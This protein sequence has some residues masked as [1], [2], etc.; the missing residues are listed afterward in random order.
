[1]RSHRLNRVRGFGP[2]PTVRAAGLMVIAV[3]LAGCASTGADRDRPTGSDV[4]QDSAG[5]DDEE[6]SATAELFAACD[7]EHG[8]RPTA[9]DTKRRLATATGVYLSVEELF[10]LGCV[11]APDATVEGTSGTLAAEWAG[12]LRSQEFSGLEILR[13]LAVGLL[14]GDGNSAEIVAFSRLDPLQ[15][16]SG[17]LEKVGNAWLITDW[18][19]D[20]DCRLLE[21]VATTDAEL[22]PRWVEA[23]EAACP[24]S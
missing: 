22:A 6:D 19:Y 5:T 18:T 16:S 23:V 12:I 21:E 13:Y 8:E 10:A 7:E 3:L 9:E 14:E 15:A 1:M 11:F 17:V 2:A 24:P 20:A 4:S